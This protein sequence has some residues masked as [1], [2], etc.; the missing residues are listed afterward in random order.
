MFP[1]LR[2]WSN[3]VTLQ[4]CRL[5]EDS[6]KDVEEARKWAAAQWRSSQIPPLKLRESLLIDLRRWRSNGYGNLSDSQTIDTE[7]SSLEKTSIK[8]ETAC[9]G[10]NIVRF[11]LARKVFISTS[12]VLM[13]GMRYEALVS[14]QQA[15][16]LMSEY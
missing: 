16:P 7:R 1:L 3:I 12:I 9:Q 4:A 6:E 8:E 11:S 2:K 10:D 14:Y 5:P 15:R 13:T